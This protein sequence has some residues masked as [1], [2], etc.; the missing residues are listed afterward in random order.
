VRRR[1][2]RCGK[3]LPLRRTLGPGKEQFGQQWRSQNFKLGYSHFHK[4]EF[5][6]LKYSQSYCK[7]ATL[8]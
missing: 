5:I 2:P 6:G 1:K 7:S 8:N 4:V 3:E